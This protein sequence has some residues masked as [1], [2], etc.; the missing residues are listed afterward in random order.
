MSK[1]DEVKTFGTQLSRESCDEVETLLETFDGKT[2]GDKFMSMVDFAKRGLAQNA[3]KPELESGLMAL[4]ATLA[5]AV[6]EACGFAAVA[7]E[8]LK[9]ETVELRA[10]LESK[11]DVI[12]TIQ[13]ELYNAHRMLDA[14]K[15]AL[16]ASAASQKQAEEEAAK[17][18][19]EKDF[20]VR[21]AEHKDMLI[22]RLTKENEDLH[23]EKDAVKSATSALENEIKELKRRL[24]EMQPRQA[25]TTEETAEEDST[26]VEESD[27][28]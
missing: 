18:R 12:G 15:S 3:M 2:K 20:A 28:D 6:T 22:E 10:K 17:C 27:D 16:D 4:K 14:S 25:A 1:K 26:T 9:S 21:A 11:D 7:Q 5:N 19:E 13:T 24:A 8:L 23:A